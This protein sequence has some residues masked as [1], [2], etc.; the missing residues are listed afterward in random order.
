MQETFS[1]KVHFY[2]P[3]SVFSS[4]FIFLILL[5]TSTSA[6]SSFSLSPSC[7]F[8]L[9][10]DQSLTQP[11]LLCNLKKS[12]VCSH[13]PVRYWIFEITSNS[14]LEIIIWYKW[15]KARN[16]YCGPKTGAILLPYVMFH[17]SFCSCSGLEMNCFYWRDEEK[18]QLVWL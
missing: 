12:F 10:S 8:S 6:L 9:F 17:K 2:D 15:L 1:A 14:S 13:V 11:V 5:T 4:I 16:G 18:G 7:R 3:S